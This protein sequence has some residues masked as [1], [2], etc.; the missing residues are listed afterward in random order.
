MDLKMNVTG[1]GIKLH[2]DELPILAV[3]RWLGHVPRMGEMRKFKKNL[4][5]GTSWKT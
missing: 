5:S 3:M 1:K 4:K 2:N